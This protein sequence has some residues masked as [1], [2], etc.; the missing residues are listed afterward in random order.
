MEVQQLY[1]ALKERAQY[2]KCLYVCRAQ[3]N[4]FPGLSVWHTTT[5][6]SVAIGMRDGKPCLQGMVTR[7]VR[8]Y[9]DGDDHQPADIAQVIHSVVAPDPAK[10]LRPSRKRPAIRHP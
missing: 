5:G 3:V 4:G 10:R 2:D 1:D 7:E 6:R 8:A 9:N